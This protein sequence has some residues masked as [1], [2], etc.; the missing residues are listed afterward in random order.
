MQRIAM[1][2]AFA[3][4]ALA[5]V[6]TYSALGR[7]ASPE[8]DELRLEVAAL[9]REVQSLRRDWAEDARSR[10]QSPSDGAVLVDPGVPRMAAAP[11]AQEGAEEST[12]AASPAR[13]LRAEEILAGFDELTVDAKEDA[14][15]ELVPLA[16]NGD[17]RALQKILDTLDDP[18]AELREEAVKALGELGDPAFFG[19]LLERAAD[20]D[21]E[22]REEV[23]D[24][25]ARM[26]PDRAGPVLME[27]LGDASIDVVR[28]SIKSLGSLGYRQAHPQLL[29]FVQNENLDVVYAAGR[30][31]MKLGDEAG[32]RNA[33]ERVAIGLG[34]DEAV[35]RIEAVKRIG[36]IG[37]DT[38]IT[39]LQNV[40]AS[41]KSIT[42][43]ESAQKA[44][45]DLVD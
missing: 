22:V 21:Y 12:D 11:V 30:A 40:I 6:A 41:D 26:S 32:A 28:S 34:S 13:A 7:R 2:V 45:A 19:H 1:G 35:D 16:R 18:E 3:S 5:G 17:E 14:I 36:K 27:M 31:L 23:A 9:A 38:A 25:L 24:A 10:N 39:Y 4:F 44:L 8:T 43:R 33:L 37:G 29:E 42:V 20:P 15:E